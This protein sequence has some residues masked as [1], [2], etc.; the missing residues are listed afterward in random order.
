MGNLSGK[1]QIE[2]FDST[3]NEHFLCVIIIGKNEEKFIGK[4]IESCI[5]ALEDIEDY[6]IIFVDSLSDDKTVEI[7]EQYD[8]NIYQLVDDKR[9]SAAAGRYIGSLN[10]KSKYVFYIDGDMI[11]DPSWFRN[12][13]PFMENNPDICGAGGMRQGVV[14]EDKAVSTK[15][16]TP[17][18]DSFDFKYVQILDGGAALFRRGGLK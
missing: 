12:A 18:Q 8:I 17:G 16:L 15:P 14:A 5:K 13:I 1:Q 2:D 9:L 4:C 3:I 6:E 11:L 7:A 10:S